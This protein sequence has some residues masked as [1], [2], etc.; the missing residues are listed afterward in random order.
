MYA[1]MYVVEFLMKQEQQRLEKRAR[2]SWM[3]SAGN[4]KG[5]PEMQLPARTTQPVCCCQAL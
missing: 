5:K 2:R 4:D 1:N 3:W